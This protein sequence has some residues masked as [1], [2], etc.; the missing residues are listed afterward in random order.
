MTEKLFVDREIRCLYCRRHFGIREYQKIE[1]PR[2]RELISYLLDASIF[3]FD[4]PYCRE[5]YTVLKDQEELVID[6][7]EKKYRI[8]YSDK[9]C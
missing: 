3:E 5:E 7:Q 6:N 8:Y 1:L 2:Q 4:C 9:W